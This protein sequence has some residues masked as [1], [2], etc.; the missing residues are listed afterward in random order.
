MQKHRSLKRLVATMLVPLP[1]VGSLDSLKR[2]R[3]RPGLT[4]GAVCPIRQG[5]ELSISRRPMSVYPSGS[6]LQAS[7]GPRPSTT[8]EIQANR[9]LAVQPSE[10]IEVRE[11]RLVNI[12]WRSDV[13]A[14]AFHLGP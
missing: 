11:P 7:N 13:R 9:S 14:A 3:W 12:S 2:W 1:K 4:N 8:S 6:A 5:C 10:V